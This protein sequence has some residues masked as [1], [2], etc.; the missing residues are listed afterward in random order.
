M[1]NTSAEL[2]ATSGARTSRASRRRTRSQFLVTADETSLTELE[3][4]LATLPMCATGR[5]FVEVADASQIAV[6]DV[7]SRL[8]ITWLDRSRRSGTPGSSTSCTVGA[9]LTRAVTGWA[10]EMLCDEDSRHEA[11]RTKVYLLGGFL[12]TADILDHLTDRL[13]V[14][15]ERIHTPERFGLIT[16][17]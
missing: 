15:A 4:V 7:P 13:D 16:E 2:V 11:E 5:V 10:D 6:L 12:G 14:P 3:T 8:T 1:L 17:R 9:A